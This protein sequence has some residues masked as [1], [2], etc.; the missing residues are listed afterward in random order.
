MG[1]PID[2]ILEHKTYCSDETIDPELLLEQCKKLYKHQK[3]FQAFSSAKK[4][5]EICPED[6]SLLS[7]EAELLSAIKS[8][9]EEIISAEKLFTDET[10]WETIAESENLST[11]YR[12]EPGSSIHT[13]KV[14]GIVDAPI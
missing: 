14:V 3:I 7:E 1:D 10:K 4:L 5:Q 11:Y 8:E 12:T 2:Q 13:I 9:Y 6:S